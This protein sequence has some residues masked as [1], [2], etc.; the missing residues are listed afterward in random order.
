MTST[1]LI[2]SEFLNLATT[3]MPVAFGAVIVL[4]AAVNGVAV[5]AGTDMDGSKA[6][7]SSGADQQSLVAFAANALMLAALFGA[8]GRGPRV[9]PQHRRS[10]PT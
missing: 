10:P 2:R 3:R 7:I 8:I 9:R 4:L 6:F 1:H 5:V